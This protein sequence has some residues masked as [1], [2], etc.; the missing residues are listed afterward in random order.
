MDALK[1]D[2]LREVDY[3]KHC[4]QVVMGASG[5]F[6]HR[7]T[8]T[9]SSIVVVIGNYGTFLPSMLQ[10]CLQHVNYLDTTCEL[11]KT[12]DFKLP[13]MSLDNVTEEFVK[14]VI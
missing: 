12:L 8:F 11:T 14:K 7:W 5:L 10:H 6:W 9:R 13:I 4:M 1:R 3:Q 2:I